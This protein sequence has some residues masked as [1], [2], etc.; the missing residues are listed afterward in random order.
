MN[1]G[2]VYRRLR[3]L[4][5]PPEFRIDVRPA[6]WDRG[7]AVAIHNALALADEVSARLQAQAKQLAEAE[8][9]ACQAGESAV[10]S[11]RTAAFDP[12]FACALCNDVFRLQ[13]NVAQLARDIGPSKELRSIDRVVRN[14]DALLKE[15]GVEYIDL[16]DRPFDERSE[17]FEPLGQPQAVPGLDHALI[18]AC[19]RP[20]VLVG[21]NLVQRARGVVKRPA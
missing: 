21:G 10:E 3:Q 16:T 17:D 5:F 7:A 14:V 1:L 8:T 13:R 2:T 18:A 20:V 19:E 6:P 15:K 11:K 9:G 4:T 12:K